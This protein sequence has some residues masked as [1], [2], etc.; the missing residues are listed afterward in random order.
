MSEGKL[1]GSLDLHYCRK[2]GNVVRFVEEF[3]GKCPYCTKHALR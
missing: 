1:L 3:C 2:Y